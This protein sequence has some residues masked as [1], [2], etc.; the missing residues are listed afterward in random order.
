GASAVKRF[1][2]AFPTLSSQLVDLDRLSLDEALD[3]ADL[4]IVH[5]WN[6]HSLI[7]RIG[8]HKNRGGTY[9]LL[10]HD[11]HH[12]SVTDV[13]SMAA[14]RLQHYDGVL[15]FGE[16]IRERYISLGWSRRAWTWHEAADTRT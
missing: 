8:R 12:R 1:H 4:V 10:F 11:T 5:E 16:V 3:D 15:A 6:P 9:T 13:E 2:R 7:E 14:Y